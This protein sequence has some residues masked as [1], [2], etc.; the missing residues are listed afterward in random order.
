MQSPPTIS[1]L[2]EATGISQSYASMILS[3]VRPPS[4]GLAVHIFRKT[5]W[6]HSILD[7]LSDEEI[8]LLERLEP[9][10]RKE[11]A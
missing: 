11:A 4:R 10:S 9:W 8:D 7:G 6:R 1:E 3:G 2:R 5:E